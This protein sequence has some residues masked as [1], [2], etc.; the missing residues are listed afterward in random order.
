MLRL[1]QLLVSFTDV[2]G[3]IPQWLGNTKNVRGRFRLSAC[4]RRKTENKKRLGFF[5]A[6]N[7]QIFGLKQLKSKQL[8]GPSSRFKISKEDLCNHARVVG[9]SPSSGITSFFSPRKCFISPFMGE[10]WP[11]G[12]RRKASLAVF[13]RK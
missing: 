13:S 12:T 8:A 2:P 11:R 1:G 4:D 7:V 3:W 5:H 9:V 6:E 10:A